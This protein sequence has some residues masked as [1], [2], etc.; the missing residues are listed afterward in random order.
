M[1]TSWPP[2]STTGKSPVPDLRI[3]PDADTEELRAVV[4]AFLQRHC[5][6]EA[7]F[8]ELDAERGWDP[9]VW[10]RFAGDRAPGPSPVRVAQ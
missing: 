1:P 10:A 9:T 7:V 8:R 6:I 4:R 3:T 5:D 2:L